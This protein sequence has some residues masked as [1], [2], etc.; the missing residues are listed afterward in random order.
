ML[1]VRLLGTFE[2]KHKKNTVSI[3]SRPAQSL[4]AYLILNAGNSHRREKLAGMLWPDSLEETARDN[5]RHALWRIRKALPPD[6]KIEYLLVDDLS[7]AFNDSADYGLD[8]GKIEKLSEIASADELINALSDYQGELL[9]G[10]YDEWVILEREHLSSI[11]EHH[12]ARLMSLLQDERRW[13]EI[14]DWGERWIKLGQKP[15]PAYR[16]LMSAHA[17]E[18]DMSKVAAT[19]ERC[20]KSLREYGVEP[21]EQT[22]LL[23]KNLKSRKETPKGKTFGSEIAEGRKISLDDTLDSGLKTREVMALPNETVTFLFTDIEG[24]TKLAQQYPD[25]MPAL[26]ARHNEILNQAIRTHNGY[27]F[28]IIGDAFCAAFHSASPALNAATEAQQLLHSEP[29]SPASIKVRMGIHTGAAQLNKDSGQIIYSGYTT[30]ALT[31]RILS[32]GH[33]GQILLSSATREL[34]LK[35]LPPKSELLDLGEKLLKDLMQPEHLYQLNV[36]GLPSIFPPLKTL[37][38]IRNNLPLQ[39]T[40]FIGRE[41]EIAEIKELLANTRL[42]TLTGPGGTGKTRLSLQVAAGMLD[43]LPDGVWFVELAPLSDPALVPQAVASVWNL[44]EQPGRSLVDTLIDYLRAKSLLLILDNCEHLIDACAQ[45]VTTLLGVCPKLKILP[46][47]RE[48]LGVA[49]EVVYRVPS[50]SLPNASSHSTPDNLLQCESARLFMERAQAAQPHFALTPQNL[51]AVAQI[52][53]RL[54]G[55]PLALELAAARIKLLS[56]EQITARL[57]DRFRLLTGGSRTALPRHQ[58]LRALIDWSY[59][60]LSQ[61]ERSAL[62]RLSVFA[63]GWTF[64]G[65]EAVLGPETLDLLSH[66][67]DKSLVVAEESS[68]VGE[69]RYSLLETIRQYARD[70]LLES[71]ESSI[72]RELHLEYYLRLAA[73]TESKLEGP[74]MLQA[75]NQLEPELDNIRAALEWALERSPEIALQLAARLTYFWQGRGHITEGRRWLSDTLSQLEAVQVGE[76]PREQLALR[77]KALWSSG[78]LTFGQGELIA[79]RSVLIESVRLAREAGEPRTLVI[80]LGMLGF[81]AVWMGDAATAESVVEEGMRVAQAINYEFGT[82]LIL[83]VR[84]NQAADLQH[85]FTAA[86]EYIEESMQIMR[87]VGNPFFTAISIMGSGD[88]ALMQGNYREARAHLAESERLFRELGD[89]HMAIGVQSRRAHVERQLGNYA[90]AIELYHQSVLAWQ[91]LGHRV[92]IAHEFECLAF[93]ACAQAVWQRAVLLF[94]AAET[95]REGLNSPMTA[96]ERIEYDQNLS[97]LRTQM[98]ESTFAAAWAEGRGMTLEQAIQFALKETQA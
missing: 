44:R 10:F 84:A 71:G 36:S 80:A 97:T 3:S 49:G 75:L 48:A 65:A 52:C 18:G 24:S 46:S 23:Y 15:E 87:K 47:S 55:I 25:A 43:N 2:V 14:L 95:L 85:N 28:Q 45:F 54:D 89:M 78:V 38:S 94:G 17:A 34:V 12:M 67:V 9:P 98:D 82:G 31:Q 91:E 21:S 7:I 73:E 64:E 32:A 30:L 86:Q 35:T 39:L 51:N 92:S 22:Q 79:A 72:A 62:T 40:T 77:A 96:T 61:Q 26:L 13:L 88:M 74:Q 37:D 93:I 70:K 76:I 81:T 56:A 50:L 57:D 66:L 63:G 42:L 83:N 8:A 69:I 5:L 27:V 11:F 33:G 16:A 1:E 60:L 41:K 29:W 19:Y 6:P 58:T 59:E 68:N 20:V 4:F 90:Q 53:Q